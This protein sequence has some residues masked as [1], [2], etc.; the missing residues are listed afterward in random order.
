MLIDWFTVVAQV[1]NFLVLVYL[2]KRF[3][4]GPIVRA[5]ERRVEKI[6]SRLKEAEKRKTEAN[7]K[8]ELYDKKRRE[9][10]EKSQQMLIDA[11]AEADA[12]RKELIRKA[13][14]EVRQ[15]EAR[16]H[17][18]I[19]RE[20]ASFLQET[21]ERAASHVYA[22][23]RRALADLANVDLERQMIN[24]FIERIQKM[25]KVE[26]G[27]VA[28]SLHRSEQ[29]ILV[30]SAF[31]IPPQMRHK[32][33]QVVHDQFADGIEVRFEVAADIISG[34]EL[35]VDGRKI[36]WNL[37]NYLATLQQAISKLFQKEVYQ[38]DERR[39]KAAKKHT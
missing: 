29:G 7:L 4:Y 25:D 8:A 15:I 1:V 39:S 26:L 31:E 3:L 34:I 19:E 17:E 13:R 37:E 6:A 2:L 5:M 11:R 38:E 9:L 27:A 16:W 24:V 23:A 33:E 18:A 20:K 10:D 28:E 32:I 36:S 21:R 22:T 35:K 30:R 12:R 14:L